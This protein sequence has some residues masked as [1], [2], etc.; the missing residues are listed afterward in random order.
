MVNF[1]PWKVENFIK[2][3]G[4]DENSIFKEVLKTD[5][6]SL[7][8]SDYVQ[9]LQIQDLQAFGNTLLE[10]MVGKCVE[11]ETDTAHQDKKKSVSVVLNDPSQDS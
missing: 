7:E 8:R 6:A 4:F 1:E 5:K 11:T 2:D 10:L 3:Q 9:I